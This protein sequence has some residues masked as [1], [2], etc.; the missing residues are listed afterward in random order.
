MASPAL[1]DAEIV[2]GAFTQELR[3]C[4]T[5][6]DQAGDGVVEQ[7]ADGKNGLGAGAAPCSR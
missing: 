7:G 5:G 1:R 6:Q 3:I 2:P 4:F